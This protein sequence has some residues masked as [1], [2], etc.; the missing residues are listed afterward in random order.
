MPDSLLRGVGDVSSRGRR[1]SRRRVGKLDGLIDAIGPG[2]IR[3][4][5]ML[6]L[7]VDDRAG[8]ALHGTGDVVEETLALSLVEHPEQVARLR[9]VVVAVAMVVAVGVS[10]DA[11]R[12]LLDGVVLL[13]P[14]ERVRLVIGIR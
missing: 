5:E 2:R 13:R 1:R 4:P 3:R 11:Q 8:N 6:Q 12:R 7:T 14:A 9:V 10:G